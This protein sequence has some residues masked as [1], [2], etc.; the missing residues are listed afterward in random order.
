[1][2]LEIKKY[3]ALRE[4]FFLIFINI[5]IDLFVI[6]YIFINRNIHIIIITNIVAIIIIIVV[7]LIILTSTKNFPLNVVLFQMT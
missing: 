3:F 5:I 1:M 4:K 2:K 7:R 6:I